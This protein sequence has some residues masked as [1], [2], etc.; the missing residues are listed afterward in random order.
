MEIPWL[1]EELEC[2]RTEL[3][4]FILLNLT[5]TG[6]GLELEFRYLPSRIQ[7]RIVETE[8]SEPIAEITEL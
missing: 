4:D 8:S 1:E 2:K 7:S 3:T 5:R 6:L